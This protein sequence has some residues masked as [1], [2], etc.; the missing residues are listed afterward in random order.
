MIYRKSGVSSDKGSGLTH[1]LFAELKL[2]ALS[3]LRYV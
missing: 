1:P 2:D 3:K